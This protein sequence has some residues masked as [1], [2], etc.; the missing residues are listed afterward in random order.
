LGDFFSK[1]CNLLL[2]KELP[3]L[4]EACYTEFETGST[5]GIHHSIQI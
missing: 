3:I 2:Y 1:G 4:V 5:M